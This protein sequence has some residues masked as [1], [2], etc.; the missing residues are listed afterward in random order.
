MEEIGESVQ[1]EKC[2]LQSLLV[3]EKLTISGDLANRLVAGSKGGSIHQVKS[4]PS[5]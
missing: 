3:F 2:P 5:I 1:V 4:Q